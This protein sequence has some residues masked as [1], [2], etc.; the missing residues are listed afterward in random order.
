M[1]KFKYLVIFFA[2]A[3]LSL[4]FLVSCKKN[5]YKGSETVE[6][7]DEA[8]FFAIS[9]KLGDD[10]R[11]FKFVLQ[12]DLSFTAE[13]FKTVAPSQDNPFT[14][15]FD[16][17]GKKITVFL[18]DDDT[19]RYETSA[20]NISLFGNIKGAQIY[21][22]S[23]DFDATVETASPLTYISSIASYAYSARGDSNLFDNIIVSGGISASPKLVE[24][25]NG[26]L[27]YETSVSEDV[28]YVGGV[29]AY[30]A[31][32]V[33]FKDVT[34]HLAITV[35]PSAED[36]V[37]LYKTVYAGGISAYVKSAESEAKAVKG[38][39][40]YD[41]V[42]ATGRIKLDKAAQNTV[43]GG[44]S[45]SVIGGAATDLT[46]TGTSITSVN[47]VVKGAIGDSGLHTII[48]GIFG[49][50]N[51]FDIIGASA[52]TDIVV[53][54]NKLGSYLLGGISGAVVINSYISSATY[55]G[56]TSAIIAEGKSE[57]NFG[58]I[59][60]L[61]MYSELHD[62]TVKNGGLSIKNIFDYDIS[63]EAIVAPPSDLLFEQTVAA[64]K[65]SGNEKYR[66]SGSVVGRMYGDETT[67]L[68]GYT[69]ID[70][71]PNATPV[72]LTQKDILTDGKIN[73]DHA[74]PVILES[75]V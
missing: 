10:Y 72:G 49:E 27:G 12:N 74:G 34:S 8:D 25:D 5:S 11:D 47:A 54:D 39:V 44:I 7:K 68:I 46:Y 52:K 24:F 37:Y 40:S 18:S 57:L 13:N 26:V 16:G 62:V 33:H 2:I 28:L 50:Q 21:N 22:L 38:N 35:K 20:Q 30:A 70:F 58:G 56:V 53:A 61:L 63:D 43:I 1:K 73:L 6:I 69:V 29:C 15:A 55:E 67:K 23:V 48:G 32:E 9:D 64:G 42:L 19:G 31:G 41:T 65:I 51:N 17:N 60:G 45:G 4:S 59:T 66:D 75:A 36:S 71:V 14:A 3:A